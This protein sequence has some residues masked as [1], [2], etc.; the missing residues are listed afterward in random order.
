MKLTPESAEAPLSQLLDTAGLLEM[1]EEERRLT[2]RRAAEEIEA[3]EKNRTAE[4]AAWDQRRRLRNYDGLMPG[5][6]QLLQAPPS[7]SR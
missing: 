2:I 1:G 3:W 7:D 6:R 5:V 4:Q